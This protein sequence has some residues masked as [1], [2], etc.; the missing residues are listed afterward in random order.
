MPCW[1]VNT[2]SVEFNA[3]NVE[4]MLEVLKEMGIT[5]YVSKD[6]ER[7]ETAIGTFNIKTGRVRVEEDDLKKVNSFR[8]NYSQKVV[9]IVAKRKKWILKARDRK[10]NVQRAF[11][12]QKW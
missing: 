3:K 10:M 2:V 7:V 8:V 4:L 1:E 9:D 12:A 5:A 11:V 6:K